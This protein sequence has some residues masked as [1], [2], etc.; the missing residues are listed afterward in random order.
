VK[1]TLGPGIGLLI[2]GSSLPSRTY[3]RLNGIDRG[4]TSRYLSVERDR[5][6]SPDMRGWK[7]HVTPE[8]R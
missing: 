2:Y 5:V 3:V 4:C 7:S 1:G 8:N 6:I